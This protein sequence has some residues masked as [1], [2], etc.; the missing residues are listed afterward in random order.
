[1]SQ[2]QTIWLIALI[3]ILSVYAILEIWR[4]WRIIKKGETRLNLAFTARLFLIEVIHGREASRQYKDRLMA[5]NQSMRLSGWF[6]LVGG[7]LTLAVSVFWTALLF[8]SLG[9]M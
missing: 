5:S 8:L 6:S 9:A 3:P 7:L 4:A 2:R 1:M